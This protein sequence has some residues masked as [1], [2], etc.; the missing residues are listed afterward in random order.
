[1]RRDWRA[2][3]PQT[4]VRMTLV[5]QVT[6]VT[7]SDDGT[8]AAVPCLVW[9]PACKSLAALSAYHAVFGPMVLARRYIT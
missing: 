6:K 5:C 8:K 7:C 4:Q 1:V 9:S 3:T 2:P